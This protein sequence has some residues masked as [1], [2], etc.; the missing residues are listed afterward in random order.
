MIFGVNLFDGVRCSFCV[1]KLG[2]GFYLNF[3]MSFMFFKCNF[4]FIEGES[5]KGVLVIVLGL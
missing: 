4:L 2:I 3:L 1:Y 5:F